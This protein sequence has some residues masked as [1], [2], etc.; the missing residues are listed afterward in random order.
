MAT[1]IQASET[2]L[3]IVDQARRKKGWTKK[4][5]AW[6]NAAGCISPSTL[7]RFWAGKPI[8]QDNFVAICKAIGIDDWEVIADF[9][10]IS[11]NS[12][13]IS[14]FTPPKTQPHNL[15][16]KQE[17]L[18]KWFV[19]EVRAGR[20]DEEEIYIVWTFEGANF[21]NY[22]GDTIPE[23]KLATFDALQK[24]G[25]LVCDRINSNEY[26]FTLTR[27]AYEI[28]DSSVYSHLSRQPQTQILTPVIMPIPDPT[29]SLPS[30][31]VFISY[32]HKDEDLRKE[33]DIHL[34]NLK[35]QGRIQAWHDRAIEAGN[36]WEVEISQQLEAAEVILLLI[37]P[38]FI[39]SN[40]C[41]EREMYRAMQRHEE[42][43]ARVVP[44]I[45]K[46]CDWKD[47]PFSKL[48]ALPKDAKPITKW[49]NQDEAFLNV[50]EGIRRAVESLSK[51]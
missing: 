13:Q 27:R 5:S 46:P 21:V 1:S 45:L 31:S 26:R 22:R 4:A 49:D 42:G 33:L 36:E 40:F 47:M 39:A 24:D 44:I 3:Q 12:P 10:S 29:A 48:Q 50:V 9:P 35:R 34:A 15:T 18:L 6:C 17:S 25:C 23:I 30:F 32:S 41:Y 11:D 20:L 38:Q 14:T 28:V 7:D 51:K 37:S 8:S 16:T 43:T 19:D 2:G